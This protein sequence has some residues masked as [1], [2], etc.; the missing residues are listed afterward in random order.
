M[1]A[2][3]LAAGKSSRFYPFN[4]AHKAFLP[5]LGKPLIM[6]TVESIVRSHITDIIIVVSPDNPIQEALGD[7]STFGAHISYITQEETHGQGHA[8]L[9]ARHLLHDDFFLMHGHRVDFHLYKQELELKRKNGNEV[10]FLGREEEDVSNFGVPKIEGDRVLDL[11]EKPVPGTEPSHIRII[12]IYLLTQEFL[13]V[14]EKMPLEHYHLEKALAEF[15]RMGNARIALTHKLLPTLKH[16]WDILTFK[17]YMLERIKPYI[18]NTA[19]V[20]DGVKIIGNVH[21]EKGAKIMEGAC[22]K[23]PAYIGKNVLIGNNSLVR[24]SSD[25]EEGARIGAYTEIRGSLILNNSSIHSG[26]I[27]DSVIGSGSKI[28]AFFCT[29]NV[30]LDRANIKVEVN[31]RKLDT[32]RRALGVLMGE[33]ARV[34]VHSAVMPGVIIGNNVNI[35]PATTVMKNVKDNCTV[36]IKAE[37]EVQENE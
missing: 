25:I 14:L 13:R 31:E 33:N 37:V 15:A 27:G 28:G 11:V 21:I 29:A 4:I 35:G 8:L 24:D 16:S 23:G 7:G 30:R 6:H 3:I 20:A 17:D 34:G 12:G 2:V 9:C 32:G 10:V 18:A 5:I 36:Y 22:I 1:Q 19:S 26:F